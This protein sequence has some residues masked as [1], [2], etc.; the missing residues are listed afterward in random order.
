[1]YLKE[2]Y[3]WEDYPSGLNMIWGPNKKG[4]KKIEI[5]Q[6]KQRLDDC[7]EDG[8]KGYKLRN[9]GSS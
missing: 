8:G 2:A 4:V 1:M 3:K 6:W 5:G 9:A 7:T